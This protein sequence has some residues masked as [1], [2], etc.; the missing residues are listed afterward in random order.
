MRRAA[1]RSRRA[2]R[3]ADRADQ[4]VVRNPARTGD[5]ELDSALSSLT[6]LVDPLRP[7]TWVSVPRRG[8]RGAYLHRLAAEGQLRF[9]PGTV[10]GPRRYRI[11]GAA[12]AVAARVRLDAVAQSTGQQVEVADAAF[13]ALAR[14][15]GLDRVLYPGSAGRPLR[16]R[17]AQLTSGQ[18]AARVAK[19]SGSGLAGA[20]VDGAADVIAQAAAAASSPTWQLGKRA[21]PLQWFDRDLRLPLPPPASG[22][23]RSR[24]DVHVRYGPAQMFAGGLEVMNHTSRADAC[25]TD[26]PDRKERL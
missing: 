19:T 14:A 7:V 12:R 21:I 17:L 18:W 24:G 3:E 1:A 6:G 5:P 4:I 11:T 2:G 22:D 15:I 10:L 23:R 8:I 9:E 16:A 26:V 20:E 25:A 13:G